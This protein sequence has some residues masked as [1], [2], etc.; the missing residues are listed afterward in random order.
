MRKLF[1]MRHAQPKVTPGIPARLWPLTPEGRYEALQ[2]ARCLAADDQPTSLYAS[3][4]RKAQETAQLI[5]QHLNLPLETVAD[6]R[7]HERE[8]VPFLDRYAWE[9]T[10][11][12]FFSHPTELI[13]G[14]ESA[15]QA[16]QRFEV[17]VEK[18]IANAL[19]G[20]LTLVTHGTVMALFVDA[21]NPQIDALTFWRSL[22]LPDLVVLD[23][24]GFE[25]TGA[26]S[27]TIKL[28]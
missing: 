22:R 14:E 23:L 21:H 13:F 24:P 2:L 5:A 20:N 3:P 27:G 6:L 12:A 15:H 4:E 8:H 28:L 17:A 11:T 1:L 9:A 10:I 16:L 26:G 7:E 18:I 25:L 19:H